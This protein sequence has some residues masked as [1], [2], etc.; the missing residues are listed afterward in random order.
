MKQLLFVVF[1][2]VIFATK[3]Q[4]FV[5]QIRTELDE[6]PGKPIELDDGN[7]LVPV[8]RG[9]FDPA[10]EPG[11]NYQNYIFK[12]D[13]NGVITDSVIVEIDSV[14]YSSGIRLMPYNDR[15]FFWSSIRD[16]AMIGPGGLRYGYLSESLEVSE[17]TILFNE[18]T[19]RLFNDCIVNESNNLIF[20]G[21]EID[22]IHQFQ[23]DIIWEFNPD[24]GI[25]QQGSLINDTLYFQL[26]IELPIIDKYH[27]IS[28]DH[29]CQFNHELGFEGI[30]YS[31]PM[32]DSLLSYWGIHTLTDSTY[33]RGAFTGTLL[34]DEGHEFGIGF[35]NSLGQRTSALIFGIPNTD[36]QAYSLDCRHPDSLIVG[37][38]SRQ[39]NSNESKFG[40]FSIRRSGDFNWQLYYGDNGAYNLFSVLATTDG[41]CLVTGTWWD[42]GNYYEMQRDVILLKLNSQGQLVT[43]EEGSQPKIGD[44]MVYPNPGNNVLYI[45]CGL[46]EGGAELYDGFGRKII[47]TAFQSGTLIID[48]SDLAKGLYY[49]RI[50]AGKRS[51]YSGIWI[52]ASD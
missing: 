50:I 25:I 46:N 52:K 38:S 42:G 8:I 37:G 16:T 4:T 5:T 6:V 49:Y 14:F 27:V 15:I 17:E 1:I 47:S 34:P 36:D 35:F 2:L 28:Y 3:A 23:S 20:T 22:W 44:H 11:L 9:I 19:G 7:F 10:Q 24:Q 32:E 45:E 33:A 26:I 43:T 18:D 48:T 21:I 12:V 41:G 31:H 30:V 13:P 40:V 51:M 39:L 29:I